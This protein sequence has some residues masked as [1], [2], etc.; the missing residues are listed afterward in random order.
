MSDDLD[1]TRRSVRVLELLDESAQAHKA[2]DKTRADLLFEE[3]SKLDHTA[4]SIIYGG[5]LIGEIPRPDSQPLEWAE[6]LN[7]QRAGLAT[8]EGE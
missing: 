3:A 7:A 5:M 4:V 8:L 2:G 6:F 1:Q